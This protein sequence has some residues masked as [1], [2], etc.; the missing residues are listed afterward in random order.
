MT[1]I[2]LAGAYAARDR[3]RDYASMLQSTEQHQVTSRW[4][5]DDHDIHPGAEGAALGQ[6]ASYANAHV[7]M[8]LA[9]IQECDVLV[10]FT[11]EWLVTWD[12]TLEDRVLHSGGRHVETGYALGLHKRVIVMGRPEN[13]FHRALEQ[14]TTT[15]DLLIALRTSSN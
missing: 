1:K 8:D 6:S 13:I 11:A 12:P 4:L 3:L 2:Y 5:L 15:V 14:V 9:D 10:V 7:Q